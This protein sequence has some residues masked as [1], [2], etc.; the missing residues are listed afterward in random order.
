MEDQIRINLYFNLDYLFCFLSR[1]SVWS[2]P[3]SDPVQKH[4]SSYKNTHT[5]CIYA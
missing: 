3:L 1:D 5:D 4:F 2:S